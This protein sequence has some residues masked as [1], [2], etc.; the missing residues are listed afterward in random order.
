MIKHIVLSGGG[1][2]NITQLGCLYELWNKNI[3][4]FDLIESVYSTS[5]GALLGLNVVLKYD[6][7]IVKDFFIKRPWHKVLSF[8]AE[9]LMQM[10]ENSGYID[11]KFI[12]DIIDI[13]LSAKNISKDI[14][15]IE[16]Y[17]LTNITFNIYAVKLSS[18]EK[19]V[20]NH[21]LSPSISVKNAILMSC[22]LPPMFKPI[23]YNNEYYL[24]GGIL[25]NYPIN[26]CL[27]KYPNK[28]EILGLHVTALGNDNEKNIFSE[29]YTMPDY[30]M[31]LIKILISNTMKQEYVSDRNEII[32][33]KKNGAIHID[34]WKIILDQGKLLEIYNEGV[35]LADNYIKELNLKTDQA[36]QHSV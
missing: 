33:K 13:F 21:E 34:T 35:D 36:C 2:N 11:T 10:V 16:L 29:N 9:N 31:L 6:M 12:E 25:C 8:K 14:T 7:N 22:A 17:N 24:D 3:I 19:V 15:F 30:M 20:F 23:L 18:F 5:A 32:I 27:L 26:D 28:E 1:P 4:N